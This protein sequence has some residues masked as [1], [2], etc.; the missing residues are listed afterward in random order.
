MGERREHGGRRLR[1]GCLVGVC[2]KLN[3]GYKT[4]QLAQE[5]S[6]FIIHALWNSRHYGPGRV[7]AESG[8]WDR[9]CA[10]SSTSN[11]GFSGKIGHLTHQEGLVTIGNPREG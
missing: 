9:A 5:D 10:Q 1:R 2:P 4:K 3:S 11:G 6:A 8:Y 7:A